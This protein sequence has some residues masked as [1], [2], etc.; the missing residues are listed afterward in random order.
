[1]LGASAALLAAWYVLRPLGGEDA[2]VQFGGE[3]ARRAAGDGIAW[4]AGLV[5][6]NLAALFNAWLNALVIYWG[7][8]TQPKFLGA[9][10]LFAAGIAAI[11]WRAWRR[12]LDGIYCV[13][14]LAILAAWPFPGQMYR[15]ALPAFPLMLAALLWAVAQAL[16]KRLTP[17]RAI[18]GACYAAIIPL[19]FCVPALFYIAQRA[20]AGASDNTQGV[21]DIMEFYRIPFRPQAEAQAARQLRAFAD[22][23][24]IRASTRAGDRVM[25]YGPAYVTLLA[26]R[27]AVA[28]EP[29]RDAAGLAAQ[30]RARRADY[31]YLSTIHPRDSAQRLGDP[32]APAREFAGIAPVVWQRLGPDGGLEA[33][34]FDTRALGGERRP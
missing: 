2:Y 23:D 4:F 17:A 20:G 12:E 16:R 28:L 14:F 22:M 33:A 24:R 26:Q 18:R 32:L 8:A 34:L 11:A 7:E 30:A 13:I 6:A 25:A 19:A 3:V 31:V 9:A 27:P 1:M 15:L 29:P 5:A 21:Q 10:V